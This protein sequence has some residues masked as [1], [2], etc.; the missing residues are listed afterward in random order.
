[1]VAGTWVTATVY[2]T[3]EYRVRLTFSDERAGGVR[4]DCSCPF[5]AEGNFCKHCVAT[6]LAALRSGSPAAPAPGTAAPADPEPASFIAWLKSLSRDELL[7]ELLELLT[8]EPQLYERFELRAAARQVDVEG[9]R[10]VVGR[11]I[12]ASDGVGFDEAS[13]YA[14][15][16]DRAAE[17]IGELIDAGAAAGAV[18]VARD[19]IAWLRQSFATIDDSSGDVSNAGYGL[20]DVH[21]DACQE[22]RPDPVELAG[23]LADLCLTD[24]YGLRPALTDYAGLLGDAGRAALRERV[25]AAY[26]ASSDDSHVR[27]VLESA[28]EADGDTDGLVALCARHLDQFGYEHLHIARTLDKA[29]RPDEALDWAERG[30]G[31]RVSAGLVE[32]LVDRYTS[33]GR[34]E[35][36][37]SLRR[38]LFSGDRSLEN[39]RALRSAATNYG[40]W[41]A[42]RAA[43]LGLLRKDAAAV[44][45]NTL[46]FLWAGPVLID[47]LIDEGDT[48]AAWIAARD[49]ASE[50]QWIRLANASASS[51]PADA[52][53]VYLT[54]IERLTQKTGDA[55]YRE[56][57]THLLAARAC[58]EA[59]GTMDKF[60]QYMMMLRMGQKRK[61]NLMATLK[62]NGL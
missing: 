21:L 48:D 59:L 7:S 15:D 56:I 23:Y 27:R 54:V 50:P 9:V 61:R 14:R 43:A 51:R 45:G 47:A 28:I 19:A 46:S 62:Q 29:G 49:I 26:E 22:A 12:W 4:G 33:A 57:A 13:A 39:F 40:V 36:V 8:D 60:R 1:V 6:G 58:H 35:D 38:T 32:Y 53:A 11:L 3:D 16:V 5:G 24:K 52:L 20:L 10:D 37:V 55:V 18:E 42:E 17:A 34:E 31:P 41:D 2:G 44:R 30:V 25:A